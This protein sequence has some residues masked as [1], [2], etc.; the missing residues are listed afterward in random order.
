MMDNVKNV[1]LV[2]SGKGGVGKSSVAA[3]LSLSLVND[4]KV[5]ILDIDLTGPSIPKLF[6]M[7]NEKIHQSSSGWV[8]VY[9][10]ETCNLGI[11]SVGF[12]LNSNQDAVIWRGPK[13]TAMIKQFV[14]DVDWQALDYLIIDTPPGTSD[15]H[16]AIMGFL[17]GFKGNVGAVIVTTP[18]AVS[19][20][21][22]KREINFCKKV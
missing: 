12:L 15:E 21:D 6:G 11:I 8:P 20:Q 19:L 17:K 7:E 5:G 10:N 16:I 18:Q 4:Y 3:Q 1:L 22:V 9:S 14:N 2:L 13:K